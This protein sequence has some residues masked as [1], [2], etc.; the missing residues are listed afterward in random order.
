LKNFN[1]LFITLRALD[2]GYALLAIDAGR[3]LLNAENVKQKVSA[4]L[5]LTSYLA[6]LTLS[7][8]LLA[9][10]TNVIGLG[11]AGSTCVALTVSSFLYRIANEKEIKQS[12]QKFAPAVAA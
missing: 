6:E 7:A 5:D 4:G 2:L 9:G 12:A 3:R 10:V 8:I 1:C 11:V